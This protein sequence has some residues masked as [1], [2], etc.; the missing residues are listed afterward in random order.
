MDIKAELGKIDFKSKEVQNILGGIGLGIII[1]IAFFKYVYA[2]M[3]LKIKDL[4]KQVEE[5]VEVLRKAEEEAKRLPE[6]EVEFKALKVELAHVEKKLPRENDIPGLLK[7]A[8]RVGRRYSIDITNFSPRK[9][10]KKAYYTL[11]PMEISINTTYHR[12]GFFMTK[13]AQQER[14]LGFKN[15]RITSTIDENSRVNIMAS[16]MLCAYVYND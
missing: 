5:K 1:I 8:T 14:V 6:L 9:E 16:F 4:E 10:S 11:L 7:T 2:P 12:L 15:L 13:M 3:G